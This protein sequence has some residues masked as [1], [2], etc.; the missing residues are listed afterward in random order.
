[1]DSGSDERGQPIEVSVEDEPPAM[2]RVRTVA[3]LLDE[4][5]ELPVINYKIGLDPIL[6]ILPVGGDAVSAAISLY[7][8]AE[9][10]QMGASRDTLL[11]MLFNVGVDAVV[12]SVPVLGTVI[13]AVW[14]ANER[15]VALLEEEL[16]IDE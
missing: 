14:K 8:V 10:A 2:E 9:G 12:G 7:I 6:G 16:G 4:A 15:N 1:M 11:K 13:D 5:I 3:R